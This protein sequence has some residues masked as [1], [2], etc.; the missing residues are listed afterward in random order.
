[1]TEVGREGSPLP[2]LVPAWGPSIPGFQSCFV[3]CLFHELSGDSS[4]TWISGVFFGI[5]IEFVF[6]VFACFI[7]ISTLFNSIFRALSEAVL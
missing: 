1:M 5:N 6:Y 4:D 2:T 3:R 7:P